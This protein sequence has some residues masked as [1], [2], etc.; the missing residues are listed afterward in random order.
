MMMA[1]P[2]VAIAAAARMRT[3]VSMIRSL[4]NGST[5]TSRESGSGKTGKLRAPGPKSGIPRR[6]RCQRIAGKAVENLF[7]LRE[8]AQVCIE[9]QQSGVFPVGRPIDALVPALDRHACDRLN[10]GLAHAVAPRCSGN[11][12]LLHEQA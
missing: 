8:G 1:T 9:A 3:I 10:Q 11:E 5:R 4:R 2:Q 12:Q 6:Q 7:V